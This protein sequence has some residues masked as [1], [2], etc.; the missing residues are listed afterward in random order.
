M[1]GTSRSV[2]IDRA[3]GEY[4]C[5]IWY[6]HQFGGPHRWE[7]R[8]DILEAWDYPGDLI[9]PWLERSIYREALQIAMIDRHPEVVPMA[10]CPCCGRT[11]RETRLQRWSARSMTDLRCERH[12]GRNPCAVDGCQRTTAG[13]A[14]ASDQWLCSEHWRRYVPPG[15]RARRAY[16][17]HFRRAKRYGWTPDSISAFHRF[18]DMLIRQVRRRSAEGHLDVEEINRVMGWE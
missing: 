11:R 2:I 15:S 10:H 9:T 14:P 5:H 17:R 3:T 16:R 13:D 7:W 6:P 8:S 4:L 1:L 18:W 12:A